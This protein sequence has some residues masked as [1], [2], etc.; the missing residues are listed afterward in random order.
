MSEEKIELPPLDI[1]VEDWD[2]AWAECNSKHPAHIS[3]SQLH[4][5]FNCR[6]RQ[7]LAA[8]K[9]IAEL[10]DYRKNSVERENYL[11]GVIQLKDETIAE[12]ETEIERLTLN[13]PFGAL[14]TELR[15]SQDR[16]AELETQTLSEVDRG[17]LAGAMVFLQNSRETH[18]KEA[19]KLISEVL[20]NGGREQK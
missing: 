17:K 13:H 19:R 4:Q 15:K 6:E 9:K 10:E 16:I 11:I 7:L 8:L 3:S 20:S 12:Q 14:Y 5:S 18:V 1:R 2:R